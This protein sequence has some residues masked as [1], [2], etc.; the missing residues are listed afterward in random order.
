[1]TFTGSNDISVLK[2]LFAITSGHAYFVDQPGD[3]SFNLRCG[4]AE[5]FLISDI[6][7]ISMVRVEWRRFTAGAGV[8]TRVCAPDDHGRL[9]K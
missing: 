7:A 3:A 4:I 1:M 2:Y 6:C 9:F 5:L 8:I